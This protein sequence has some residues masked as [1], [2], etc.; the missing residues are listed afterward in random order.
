MSF[1]FCQ[2]II[3]FFALQS[4]NVLI[5]EGTFEP[6]ANLYFRSSNGLHPIHKNT[7]V[8]SGV[9]PKKGSQNLS[10]QLNNRSLS[11][12]SLDIVHRGK[13]YKLEQLYLA[14]SF[15]KIQPKWTE[16][17][18]KTAFNIKLNADKRTNHYTLKQPI[19]VQN[20]FLSWVLPAFISLCVLLILPLKNWREFPAIK[21]LLSNQHSRNQHNLAALDG[22]RGLAALLVLFHHTATPLKGAGDLGVWMFFVLSGFLLTK[23]FVVSPKKNLSIGSLLLYMQRRF[24]RIVPMYFFMISCI[25][26]L[27][28]SFD[29]AIRHYLFIQ[30]DGHF[31]TILQE[32][33][34]YLLL[35]ILTIIIYFICRGKIL[36]TMILLLIIAWLWTTY[37][38]VDVLSTY[39]Q[40]EATRA[41]FEVFILGMFGS[42]LYYGL[43]LNSTKLKAYSN[44]YQNYISL[45]SLALF[46]LVLC[47]TMTNWL[48][49][50]LPIKGEPFEG[51]AICLFFILVSVF[52]PKTSL[53]N[54]IFSNPFLR[55]IGIIG[56]S[57]YLLHPYAVFLTRNGIEYF[58]Q[59]PPENVSSIWRVIFPLF[60]TLLFASF[61]YSFIERPFLTSKKTK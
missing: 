33:Y 32:M 36:A 61:T 23:T 19:R 5:V 55:Y 43:F 28:Y 44:K 59:L 39:G 8:S 24:K 20:H 21:D 57:F 15:S 38:S 51:A 18:I 13:P 17:E 45:I 49:F 25:F 11:T 4:F 30:G 52:S 9:L 3:H 37:G 29:N 35:P 1:I 22:F 16:N 48:N 40:N 47:A 56:Y 14:S 41:Y 46:S 31:W 27:S 7:Q 6:D 50:R 10:F 42:Y 60:I 26:L 34:F 53:Y 12:F 58:L 54:R 2:Q